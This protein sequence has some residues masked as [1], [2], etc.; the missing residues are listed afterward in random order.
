M[1][2]PLFLTILIGF[3]A[4]GTAA[5]ADWKMPGHL[6][7]IQEAIDSPRV[8]A[9]DTL[10]IRPGAYAGAFLTKSLEIRGQ[11]GTVINTG[12]L[13]PNGK[14]QGFRWT[15]FAG[16]PERVSGDLQLGRERLR[17]LAQR[18]HRSRDSVRRGY[19]G[20]YC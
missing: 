12:P 17:C 7:T 20:P 1:R 15:S 19:R 2:R 9:G 16:V 5:A 10:V 4:A 11:G 3:C 18:N 6:A 8:K 13:H 14:A